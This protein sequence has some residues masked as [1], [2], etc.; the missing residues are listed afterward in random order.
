MEN[1]ACPYLQS[2]CKNGQLPYAQI[3]LSSQ[4]SALN[5][6]MDKPEYAQIR[7]QSY[8]S[9]PKQVKRVGIRLVNVFLR[10]E[11]IHKAL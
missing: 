3:R 2:D 4:K 11:C 1:C 8:K 7:P 9:A 10:L 6:D 5:A